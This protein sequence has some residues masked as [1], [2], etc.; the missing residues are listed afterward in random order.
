MIY[1]DQQTISKNN[2]Y[3]FWLKNKTIKFFLLKD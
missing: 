3:E 1:Y 2:S